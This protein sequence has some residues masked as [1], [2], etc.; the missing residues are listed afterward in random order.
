VRFEVMTRAAPDQVLR[1]FT[2]FTERRPEIWNRTLDPTT[3]QVRELGATWAVARESTPRSPFW[4]V[5]RY[6][7][8]DPALIRWT[9]I[10]NSYGGNGSGSVR[11]TPTPDGGSHLDVEWSSRDPAGLRDRLLLF[12]LHHGPMHRLIARM[13]TSAL[14]RYADAEPT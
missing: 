11:I 7:W 2:D 9:E 12:M 14:D 13:W 4:V 3:Y 5:A 8:S 6:D 10:E 1:A